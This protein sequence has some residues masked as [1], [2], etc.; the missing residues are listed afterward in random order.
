MGPETVLARGYKVIKMGGNGAVFEGL[1][2]IN[3]GLR[4]VYKSNKGWSVRFQT[5]A[6]SKREV[7]DLIGL[8]KQLRLKPI[9]KPSGE[10]EWALSGV[11]PAPTMTEICDVIAD[12]PY[13][14][15]FAPQVIPLPKSA[16]RPFFTTHRSFVRM[17][18]LDEGEFLM[19][20]IGPALSDLAP[21]TNVAAQRDLMT[22]LLSGVHHALQ[23][24]VPLPDIGPNNFAI[25]KCKT[26]GF[27]RG[28]I[29]D[30]DTVVLPL[31]SSARNSSTLRASNPNDSLVL[32]T[33]TSTV[34]TLAV[35]AGTPYRKI[36]E[37]FCWEVKKVAPLQ[38][39]KDACPECCAPL[40]KTI[41]SNVTCEQALTALAITL[42]KLEPK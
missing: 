2:Q 16:G 29:I 19:P 12:V 34:L 13:T 28:V 9:M 14:V 25:E 23:S 26:T 41:T 5:P 36:V 7:V 39:V 24:G 30:I 10:I 17:Q 11:G 32:A 4:M 35:I 6:M 33:M 40:K 27:L 20:Y 21:I 42:K 1:C 8:P 15:I 3:D 31:K 18:Q 38:A 37:K 22:S